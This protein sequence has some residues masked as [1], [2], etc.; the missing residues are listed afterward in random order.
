MPAG[1]RKLPSHQI[2]DAIDDG[3]CGL[4]WLQDRGYDPDRIVVAGDSAG[5]YLAFMTTLAAIRTQVA[6]PA[7]VAT[8]SPFTDAN[9]LRKLKH[10]NA[11][12]SSMVTAG[13]L[14]IFSGYLGEVQLPNGPGRSSGQV[15]SP[16]DADLS[17]LPPV[18]IHAGADELL[19]PD[20]VLLAERLETNGIRC[21][22]H[23][24]AGQIHDFPVAT[25]VLP[26]GRRGHPVP[27]GFRQGSHRRV[28]VPRQR[29]GH[30]R[31]VECAKPIARQ[32]YSY[33]SKSGSVTTDCR[34]SCQSESV[35]SRGTSASSGQA[36][37]W[38]SSGAA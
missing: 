14:S 35:V 28:G 10:R 2:A 36:D 29:T 18:P 31:R 27:R 5:G 20:A 7:G 11:R 34:C 17:V 25:D 4:S 30:R 6:A 1:Y 32:G 37:A 15:V 9:P 19:L 26:E 21:D 33:S 23:L 38:S 3:L 24:W 16:V 22:L 13:A 12:K 8:V